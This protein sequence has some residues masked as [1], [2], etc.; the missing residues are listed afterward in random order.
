[1]SD[2]RVNLGRLFGEHAV[3]VS[4]AMQK[5]A[6]GA[7][8]ADTVIKLLGVNAT[9]LGG[10]VRSVAKEE[11]RL[12]F[13]DQWQ[14]HNRILLALAAASSPKGDP[15]TRQSALAE[16]AQYQSTFSRFLAESFR[17]D[18]TQLES[19]IT[20]HVS[21]VLGA[22][23]AS[24]RGDHAAASRQARVAYTHMFVVADA[25]AEPIARESGNGRALTP[26]SDLRADVGR[27]L[28]EHAVLVAQAMQRAHDRAPDLAATSETVAIN[29]AELT[30]VVASGFGEEAGAAFAEQWQTHIRL[31]SDLGGA[32]GAKDT[33]ARELALSE[34]QAYAS[35]FPKFLAEATGIPGQS[36]AQLFGRHLDQLTGFLDAYSG[37]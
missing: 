20:D 13:V 17:L 35:S 21:Q 4:M 7:R 23:D 37:V 32:T 22:F 30:A 15:A 10:A 27:L 19:L 11:V 33:S 3:L 1:G 16:L 24:V 14:S 28:A 18:R 26:A 6:S 29:A 31:L 34:L 25:L 5:R 9:A 12:A 8:D 2:L 36:L